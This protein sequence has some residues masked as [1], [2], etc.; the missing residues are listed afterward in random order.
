MGRADVPY[1]LTRHDGVLHGYL[2]YSRVIPKAT[3][4][5]EEG[6]AALRDCL[7]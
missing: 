3:Q 6:A 2:H 5:I 1:R 4:A 7:A